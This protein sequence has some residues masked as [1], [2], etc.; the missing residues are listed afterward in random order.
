M[1][2]KERKAMGKVVRVKSAK[3]TVV[4]DV[5]GNE[6][7]V[8]GFEEVA[9]APVAQ[10][11]SDIE[12]QKLQEL[13]AKLAAKKNNKDKQMTVEKT[14]SIEIGII[15][16]GQ[17]GNRLAEAF[18]AL[19]NNA[20]CLNTGLQDLKHVKIPESNKLLLELTGFGG[21]AKNLQLGKAAAE[22]NREKISALVATHF[23]NVDMFLIAT[24]AGGGSGAGSLDVLVDVL[25]QIGKPVLLMGVLPGNSD[26]AATKSNSLESLQSIASFLKSGKIANAVIIDNKRVEKIHS[27]VSIMDFFSV[28]NRSIVSTFDMLNKLSML[29]SSTKAFDSTEL[30]TLLTEPGFTVYGEM[31][32]KDYA[33]EDAIATSIIENLTNNL[34]SDGFDVEQSRYA[35]FMIAASK[36]VLDKIPAVS[37]NYANSLLQDTAK[38]AK[39]VFRGIYETEDTDDAVKVYSIF[40]GLGLPSSRVSELQKESETL[41]A[42]IRENEAK[43]NVNLDMGVKKDDVAADVQRIK[44]KV[45]AKNSTLQNFLN[46]NIIDRRSK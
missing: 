15:G 2:T 12:D 17:A 29:P 8:K 42:Q 30:I 10:S 38:A 5:F 36:A 44:D 39:A 3:E 4:D 19:G 28:A 16:T 43:R 22:A 41:K 14:R 33:Q 32:V 25:G 9:T 46:K 6:I 11:A 7:V 45:A 27:G 23:A 21:A 18:Y 1:A 34:L 37:I 35:G 26:D 31:T 24:S 40:S 13:K 20:I